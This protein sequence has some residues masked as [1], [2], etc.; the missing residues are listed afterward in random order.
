[1]VNECPVNTCL[2]SS[3]KEQ[4]EKLDKNQSITVKYYYEDKDT[5]GDGL[6]TSICDLTVTPRE[7]E[8]WSFGNITFYGDA[9]QVYGADQIKPNKNNV[10]KLFLNRIESITQGS[11][12]IK[13]E[14][15]VLPPPPPGA[16][17][18][19]VAGPAVA[20][21]ASGPASGPAA[22]PAVTQNFK[23]GQKNKSGISFEESE[24]FKTSGILNMRDL[25]DYF[26]STV[27]NSKITVKQYHTIVGNFLT[28]SEIFVLFKEH[29]LEDVDGKF[30]PN[31]SSASIMERVKD[32]L[33][34]KSDLV[35][36][37]AWTKTAQNIPEGSIIL[38]ILESGSDSNY[39][40]DAVFLDTDG[41]IRNTA[42]TKE[43]IEE[44]PKTYKFDKDAWHNDNT[45]YQFILDTT[46]ANF[47]R[48]A[49]SKLSSFGTGISKGVSN[50]GKAIKTDFIN[51][52]QNEITA[53][54][55]AAKDAAK[56][57]A[58]AAEK[59]AAAAEKAAETE[60][61]KKILDS[62]KEA[63]TTLNTNDKYKI[64]QAILNNPVSWGQ[65]SKKDQIIELYNNLGHYMNEANPTNI[66]KN[67][68][69]ELY[70]NLKKL[71]DGLTNNSIKNDDTT[72]NSELTK[73]DE[74][75]NTTMNTEA[76]RKVRDKD[77][78]D[79]AA[80]PAPAVAVKPS[81]MSR[82]SSI[83]GKGGKVTRKHSKQSKLGKTVKKVQSGGKRSSKKY[84][85]KSNGKK[86][87]TAK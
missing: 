30:Q 25:F 58:E 79:K 65:K 47:G 36:Q 61:Q 82:I 77:A 11:T 9:I 51:P 33:T 73:I 10:N 55:D 69:K 16:A 18:T 57:A 17:A 84:N 74:I 50:F 78:A 14:P 15:V 63:I 42:T 76:E 53:R 32:H 44:L 75:M 62:K 38:Q 68:E 19:A 1:M 66:D 23:C 27:D 52:I 8:P 20:G 56:D 24:V 86:N 72:I 39:R 87:K 85:K 83:F 29:L 60:L 71:N 21:P 48:S 45:K 59:V 67:I 13:R 3:F 26:N 2:D 34:N 5:C 81:V 7:N 40:I 46:I 37:P 70:N 43:K 28:E 22:G 80:A 54:A 6:T 4:I 41:K 35:T 49:Q 31:V 12:V 64:F